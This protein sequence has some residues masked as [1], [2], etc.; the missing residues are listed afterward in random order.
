[1]RRLAEG[2]FRAERSRLVTGRPA[3]AP[4]PSD[5]DERQSGTRRC[6]GR[7]RFSS[8]P[9]LPIDEIGSDAPDGKIDGIAGG[10]ALRFAPSTL[11]TMD[12]EVIALVQSTS[13]FRPC[14]NRAHGHGV[15]RA[16]RQGCEQRPQHDQQISS[17]PLR[18]IGPLL[19]AT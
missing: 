9:D 12:C 6:A 13:R 15:R 10:D 14:C 2:L 19:S 7:R 18:P 3:A 17:N 4:K 8:S 11:A 1:V 5:S 16:R